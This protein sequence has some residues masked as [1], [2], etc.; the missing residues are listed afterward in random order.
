MWEICEKYVWN[1]YEICEKCN[2]IK[3]QNFLN[4]TINLKSRTKKWTFSKVFGIKRF[5]QSLKSIKTIIF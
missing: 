2:Y 4:S 5:F 1:M 3:R